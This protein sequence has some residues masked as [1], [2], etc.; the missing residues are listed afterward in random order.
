MQQNP[1][2]HLF[3]HLP[4]AER[5]PSGS[6]PHLTF[7]PMIPLS[8]PLSSPLQPLVKHS[9]PHMGT[10]LFSSSVVTSSSRGLGSSRSQARTLGRVSSRLVPKSPGSHSSTLNWWTILWAHLENSTYRAILASVFTLGT[11]IKAGACPRHTQPCERFSVSRQKDLGHH[12]DSGRPHQ[13]LGDTARL[14]YGQNLPGSP[15]Q[16]GCGSVSFFN[17]QGELGNNHLLH[18]HIARHT[19]NLNLASRRVRSPSRAW[20]FEASTA[21]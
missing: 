7:S 5:L 8:A 15:I 12:H 14:S 2:R 21:V 13:R 6:T 10:Y 20:M 4:K 11:Q 3:G 9:L 18:G 17:R 16:Q 1:T 19:L